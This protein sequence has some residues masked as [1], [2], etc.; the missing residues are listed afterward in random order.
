MVSDFG[1][2]YL[3][4]PRDRQ[5]GSRIVH[6]H[7]HDVV[8]RLEAVR[9]VEREAG[10]AAAMMSGG[11]AV[12]P[13]ERLIIDGPEIQQHPAALPLA[14]HT[15]RAPVPDHV[16]KARVADPAQLRLEG[17]GHQN[18]LRERPAAGEP[19]LA[20]PG[21]LVVELELPPA[22]QGEPVGP[23]EIRPG[24]LG[25]GNRLYRRWRGLTG[26]LP[27]DPSWHGRHG[28]EERGGCEDPSN[29]SERDMRHRPS[30]GRAPPGRM[31]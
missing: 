4:A 2:Q 7:D 12:D 10:V 27:C 1:F 29:A 20:K 23:H 30:E 19:A 21:V 11:L 25:A 22:I 24:M 18:A 14:R 6:A 31:R 9:H 5:V 17:V 8:S 28:G 16:V 3:L 26:G 13:D 15:E